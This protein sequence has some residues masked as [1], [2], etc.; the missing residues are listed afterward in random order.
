MKILWET[1]KRKAFNQD[2]VFV[3]IYRNLPLRF[4]FSHPVPC[5]VSTRRIQIKIRFPSA[6]TFHFFPRKFSGRD[7]PICRPMTVHD[8]KGGTRS[9]PNGKIESGKQGQLALGE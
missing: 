5:A 4:L 6:R 8:S 7:Q 1:F 9:I 3:E 2:A